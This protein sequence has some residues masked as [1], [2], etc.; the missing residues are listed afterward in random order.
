MVRT[1]SN[2]GVAAKA[3]EAIRAARRG[4]QWAF[5]R[6]PVGKGGGLLS[7]RKPLAYETLRKWRWETAAN[8][9]FDPDRKAPFAVCLASAQLQGNAGRITDLHYEQHPEL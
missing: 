8:T 3:G 7:L 9:S 4:A 1:S 2:S 5:M 6:R